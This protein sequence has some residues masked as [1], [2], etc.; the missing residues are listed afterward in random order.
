MKMG[1]KQRTT[2]QNKSLHLY[3]EHLANS[4]NEAG[5]DIQKTLRHDAQIPWS[6]STVK[7][8]IFRQIMTAQ[9]GKKS[10]TELTTREVSEV[11]NTIT[12]HLGEKFGLFVDFPSVESM[13]EGSL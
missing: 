1:E 10:T 11:F 6:A 2:T 5:L 12:R 9:F 7:E 8:L 13:R 4:L 3:F